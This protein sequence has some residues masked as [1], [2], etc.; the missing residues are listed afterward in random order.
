MNDSIIEQFIYEYNNLKQ[1]L[2]QSRKDQ[3]F[4]RKQLFLIIEYI[5]NNKANPERAFLYKIIEAFWHDT[6]VKWTWD[7]ARFSMPYFTKKMDMYNDESYVDRYRIDKH[8]PNLYPKDSE[9]WSSET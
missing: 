5:R 1:E 6:W 9:E 8:I 3:N 2:E 4:Y 7:Y